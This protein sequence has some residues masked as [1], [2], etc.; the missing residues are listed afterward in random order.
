MHRMHR[1]RCH[2]LAAP[3][4]PP[5]YETVMLAYVHKWFSGALKKLKMRIGLSFGKHDISLVLTSCFYAYIHKRRFLTSKK[6]LQRSRCSLK[7]CLVCT[8]ALLW[9]W[10]FGRVPVK[11]RFDQVSMMKDAPASCLVT[12]CKGLLDAVNRSRSAGLGLPEERT[13]IEALPVRQ[14][15]AASNVSVKRGQ[16][17]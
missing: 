3:D 5:C 12:N 15:C 13:A 7:C 4:P 2:R 11:L 10:L 6:M 17:W 9:E 16:L 1:I 8:R 14:S